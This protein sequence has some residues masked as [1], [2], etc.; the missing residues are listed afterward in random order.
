MNNVINQGFCI[1]CG[2]CE[3]YLPACYS[4]KKDNFGL[5]EAK[6]IEGSGST[7]AT[8]LEDICPVVSKKSEDFFNQA[9]EA[10]SLAY[11]KG[12]G[13]YR[14]VYAGFVNDET[15]RLESS[16]GGLTTHLIEELFQ[17]GLIT[18]AI[19]VGASLADVSHTE[20]FIARSAGE[21]KQAKKSKYHMTS[22]SDI[23]KHILACS[24]QES[25]AFVGIPCSV[26][27]IRLLG[28]V[29]HDLKNKIKYTISIFC[30]HQ[31][32]HA[33][34]EYVAWQMGISPSELVSM[35]YRVKKA[36]ADASR[37]YYKATSRKDV[38][39]KRVDSLKWMDWGLG[40]FKPKACDFCDD[41]TGETADVIFGDAWSRKYSHNHRGT[42]LVITRSKEIDEILMASHQRGLISLYEEDVSFVDVTQG[43]NFRHRHEGLMSRINYYATEGMWYPPKHEIRLARY[44]RKSG[45]DGYYI[46]RHNISLDSHK[47]FFKA[48][49]L[50]DLGYFWSALSPQISS[51]Y[52]NSEGLY[53]KLK[54]FLKKILGK[55]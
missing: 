49:E 11:K 17:R 44:T 37:Y 4:L 50:N 28:E 3:A 25:F 18:G 40:L 32:S 31:K 39:E 22:H 7:E 45:R 14:K 27:A 20:Y 2:N 53:L 33:F 15:T 1:G 10:D 8:A 6:L 41:V 48:K 55:I 26:K 52:R 29:K 13:F 34:T 19:V 38:I 12:V 42:N 24:N 43:G 46:D 5:I 35:D 23:A 47:A 21:L 54:N 30:G 36:G 51:Y 16:S 9:Y